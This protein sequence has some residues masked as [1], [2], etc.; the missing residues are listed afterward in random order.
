MLHPRPLSAI[1]MAPLRSSL[2]SDKVRSQENPRPG[3]GVLSPE[4]LSPPRPSL[5]RVR[6][7]T[8]RQDSA[9][10]HREHEDLMRTPT[11]HNIIGEQERQDHSLVKL[12]QLR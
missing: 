10:G 12:H 11:P 4:L 9:E 2:P 8:L 5:S 3:R 6:K 7:T 1:T